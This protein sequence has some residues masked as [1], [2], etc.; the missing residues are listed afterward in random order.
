P[1]AGRE[2]GVGGGAAVGEGVDVVPLDAVAASA[3]DA[4]GAFEQRWWAEAEGGAQLGGEVAA[5]VGDGVDA[6]PV[7]EDR[8]DER[9]GGQ[10]PGRLHGDGSPAD[11]VADLAVFGVAALEG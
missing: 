10:V 8:F 9:H 11:D 7:V 1:A 4:G 3:V 6:D 2:V 5:Q